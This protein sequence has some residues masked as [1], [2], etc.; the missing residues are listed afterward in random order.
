MNVP[1]ELR[2]LLAGLERRL[3]ENS[4]DMDANEARRKELVRERVEIMRGIEGVKA[5]IK[6]MEGD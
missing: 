1:Q 6:T 3:N 5:E 4:Y 2:K